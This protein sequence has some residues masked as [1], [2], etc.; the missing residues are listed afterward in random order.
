LSVIA[1]S[2]KRGSSRLARSNRLFVA[3]KIER[4]ETR[5]AGERMRRIGIAVEQLDG[6]LGAVH[7][8]VVDALARDD[9][10]HRDGAGGD[11]L[12]E[13]EKVRRHAIALG[14]KGVA[15]AAEAG[16]H[17]VEDQQ[18]AVLVADRAQPIEIA[19]GRR[20]HAGRAGHR[21]DDDRGDG[22]SAVQRDDAFE[23]VGEVA[24]PL[25]ARPW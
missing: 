25:P 1:A 5:G 2:A 8:G 10:A 19:F 16:D 15:E 7:E 14:G 23:F 9:P 3:I 4:R 21:L 24:A 20:Q 22:R 11:A 18:N 12:G 17:L 13:A 6:V